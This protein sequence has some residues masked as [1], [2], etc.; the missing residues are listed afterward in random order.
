M[1]LRACWPSVY[2]YLS[3]T[4]FRR[5][6]IEVT[7]ADNVII[8]MLFCRW[9]AQLFFCAFISLGYVYVAINPGCFGPLATA[10]VAAAI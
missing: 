6:L 1:Q 10:V 8:C 7:A 9:C 5:R 4:G 2:T 3:S